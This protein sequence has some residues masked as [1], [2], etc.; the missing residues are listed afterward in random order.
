M[1]QVE[2]TTPEVIRKIMGSLIAV[3]VVVDSASF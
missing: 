1:S 2:L 3:E